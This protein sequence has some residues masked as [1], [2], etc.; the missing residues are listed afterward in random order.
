M[1]KSTKNC[2]HCSQ[3]FEPRRTNHVYCT[4]S[5]K[6]K[7]SY[8]RNGY[9]Y[10]SGHYQKEQLIEIDPENK[11]ANTNDVLE[12]IRVIEARIEHLKPSNEISGALI[13]NSA[14]GSAT[15]DAAVY[16]AKKIFAPNSLP[17]TKGDIKMLI[18]ELN[19]LKSLINT[20][21]LNKSHFEI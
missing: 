5:C 10:V 11:M 17:A 7:A 3:I 15:A 20:N 12:S 21:S 16:A 4:T 1:M 14:I 8:K 13:S 2:K 9:K 19:Q 6:T 18:K